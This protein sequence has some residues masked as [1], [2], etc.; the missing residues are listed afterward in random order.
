MPVS[1]VKSVIKCHPDYCKRVICSRAECVKLSRKYTEPNQNNI[2]WSEATTSGTFFLSPS[3]FGCPVMS[4]SLRTCW[5]ARPASCVGI[6]NAQ[7]NRELTL[8]TGVKRSLTGTMAALFAFA[9][10]SGALKRWLFHWPFDSFVST[11]ERCSCGSLMGS[12]F[13]RNLFWSD[14]I[15]LFFSS[16][17]LSPLWEAVMRQ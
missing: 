9:G 14:V 11:S 16:G 10:V 7:I 13:S 15:G 2:A 3:P 5:F 1:S 8:R 12:R 6:I 17:H 4:G